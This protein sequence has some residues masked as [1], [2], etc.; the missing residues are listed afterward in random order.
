MDGKQQQQKEK[1][2]SPVSEKSNKQSNRRLRP[3]GAT[4]TE[5]GYQP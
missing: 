4:K 5:L 3:K 2:E 1:P